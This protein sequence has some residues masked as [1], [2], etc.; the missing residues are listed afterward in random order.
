MNI[1]WFDNDPVVAAKAQPDK[2]LVKMVLETAQVL[3]GVHRFLDGDEGYADAYNLYKL[4]HKN[5]P[6]SIWARESS[7]NYLWLY[8]HFIALCEE[9]TERYERIHLSEQKL[10]D[11]L[12]QIPFNISIGEMTTP[13]QAMPEVYKHDDPVVA[14]RRYCIHEKHYAQW[15][16]VPGSKPDWWCKDLYN[17]EEVEET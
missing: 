17:I 5:H 12:S 6:S 3:S 2:M 4:T 9:Y 15:N 13:A 7:E 14:Y 10:R 11:G 1:F 16:V 8:N